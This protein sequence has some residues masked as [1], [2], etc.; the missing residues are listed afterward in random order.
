MPVR[1]KLIR[2]MTHV[3]PDGPS[4]PGMHLCCWQWKGALD[5]K[6]RPRFFHN[7]RGML[8]KRALFEILLGESLPAKSAI[9]T[10]CHNKLCVRPEHLTLCN[11]NDAR[12]LGPHGAIAP[13]RAA[14][15]QQLREDGYTSEEI[16]VMHRVS[17]PL[18]EAIL[19]E[20][21]LV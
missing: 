10:I 9:G 1:D 18:I 6:V 16:A 13:T 21:G 7:G 4:V 5:K 2:F 20:G 14:L 15:I 11:E 3:N 19:H 12:S 17:I 8:A